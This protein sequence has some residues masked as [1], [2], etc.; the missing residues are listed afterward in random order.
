MLNSHTHTHT[1]TQVN[2]TDADIEDNA[3]IKYSLSSG[4]DF[5]INA[6]TGVV[7][8]VRSFDRETTPNITVMIIATDMGKQVPYFLFYYPTPA[9]CHSSSLNVYINM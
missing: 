5:H 4:R 1:H 7:K 9:I 3:V 2:A 8:A 6:K